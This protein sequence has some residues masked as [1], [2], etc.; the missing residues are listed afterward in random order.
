MLVIGDK[1][2][3]GHFQLRMAEYK[4]IIGDFSD[5]MDKVKYEMVF[6]ETYTI[7]NV[8]FFA[9]YRDRGLSL[10][11]ATKAL[12]DGSGVHVSRFGRFNADDICEIDEDLAYWYKWPAIY[13]FS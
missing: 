3:M 4:K 13:F 7:I 2:E 10:F 5:I 8:K 11:R 1:E 9:K 6:K 12:A